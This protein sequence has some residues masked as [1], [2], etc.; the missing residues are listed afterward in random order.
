MKENAWSSGHSYGVA[1]GMALQFGN[2]YK[3][4]NYIDH[5]EPNAA[6]KRIDINGIDDVKT[7][8]AAD[9]MSQVLEART[10]FMDRKYPDMA[11]TF[12]VEA[13]P[14]Y[15]PDGNIHFKVGGG[16]EF[17]TDVVFH[18]QKG[19]VS[20]QSDGGGP[21]KVEACRGSLQ[22]LTEALAKVCGLPLPYS[23]G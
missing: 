9:L 11:G 17:K 4:M 23:N 15:L 20:A 6:T 16:G 22:G 19:I 8:M 7:R 12:A 1:E 21:P 3:S 18:A 14:D 10:A 5:D 13:G 2:D